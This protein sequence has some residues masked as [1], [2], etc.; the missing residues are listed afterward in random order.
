[1]SGTIL[2]INEFGVDRSGYCFLR[3]AESF[4]VSID[5]YNVCC[6][7]NEELVSYLI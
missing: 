7:G 1:M 2:K 3:F 4:R 5:I 6:F